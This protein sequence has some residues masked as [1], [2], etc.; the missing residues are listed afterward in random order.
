MR[1]RP[2]AITSRE[3]GK[4]ETPN[5]RETYIGFESI[6]GYFRDEF[7]NII[8]SETTFQRR[9]ERSTC[10]SDVSSSPYYGFFC[11]SLI[12]RGELFLGESFIGP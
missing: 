4:K 9:A 12:S 10:S 2:I 3:E 7:A 5:N 8:Y 6:A 1:I 11:F